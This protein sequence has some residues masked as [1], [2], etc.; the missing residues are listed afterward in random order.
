[1]KRCKICETGLCVKLE[2]IEPCV[3]QFSAVCNMCEE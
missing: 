2:H 1:L 3:V